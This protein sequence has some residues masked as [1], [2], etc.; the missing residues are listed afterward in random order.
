MG[1]EIVKPGMKEIALSPSLLGLNCAT[2]EFLT[3]YGKVVCEMKAG[4]EPEIIAPEEIKVT[5]SIS[6]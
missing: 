2:A 4:E 6:N 5:L 3:P 1:L